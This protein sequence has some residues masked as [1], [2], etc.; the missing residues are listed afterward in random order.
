[1]GKRKVT[2]LEPAVTAVAEVAFFIES[3][4]M[5]QTAKKFVNEVFK[6]FEKL[7]DDIVE[8]RRCSYKKWKDL[9]YRCLSYKKKYVIAFLSLEK[10]IIIC[11]FV[12]SKLLK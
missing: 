9:N 2:I 7:S 5:P 1:M 4:G 11:D 6:F 8:Y 3:K 12:S 10:E